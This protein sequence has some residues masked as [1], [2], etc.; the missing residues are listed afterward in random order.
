MHAGIPAPPPRDLRLDVVRG[1]LQLTIFF[2]HSFGSFAGTWLVYGA[3]GLSD[4][5]EQF[6]FLSGL[7]LGSVTARIGARDG[8][9]AAWRD[10]LRR[11]FRL[12]RTHLIV[13][14]LFGAM[15]AAAGAVLPGEA[16]RLGWGFMF[17]QPVRAGLSA[18]VLLYQPDFMGILPIFVWCML[19]LPGFD[20]LARRFGDLALLAPVGAYAL[21]RL[22]GV[23][24]PSLSPSN[25]IAF[26]VFAWQMTYLLGAWIGRR[27]LLR[28]HVV[29][30]T[31]AWRA[32][33]TVGAIVMLA[34][35]LAARL[36]W[37]GYTSWPVLEPSRWVGKED[38]V[39]PRLLHA[40]A[41]VWLVA[42][43]V[44]SE[45]G[46]MK[47]WPGRVLAAIGRHSL[48]VFCVGLFLS[49][50]VTAAFRL[51]PAQAGWTD[52]LLIATGVAV[53][54][55]VGWRLDGPLRRNAARRAESV[56]SGATASPG[57]GAA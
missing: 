29:P 19:L 41:L 7:A 14:V 48:Q 55:A 36:A 24:V 52:P 31:G 34:V 4:S 51:W 1:W 2:S 57:T 27:R 5:S 45:A 13:F 50:I 35:G 49:W 56:L 46:W 40:L 20:A 22:T 11:T 43:F 26:N 32:V 15:L 12:Y 3:W 37:E 17:D 47:T 44:P 39:L 53:L 54:S 28:G 21:V 42:R 23:D 10:M 33:L 30:R 18:L 25:G 6:I 16:R 38:L 9:M 8:P